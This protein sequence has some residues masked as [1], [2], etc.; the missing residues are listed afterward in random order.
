MPFT[1][2]GKHYSV[3][4]RRWCKFCTDHTEQDMVS[5]RILGN[6]KPTV[7]L[8]YTREKEWYCTQCDNID[9]ESKQVTEPTDKERI[10]NRLLRLS[11]DYDVQTVNIESRSNE[12]VLRVRLPDFDMSE[13]RAV[14]YKQ[15]ETGFITADELMKL[16]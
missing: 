15:Q 2:N 14:Q 10:F 11:Q 3:R 5:N 8:T 12:I 7:P 16:Q 13:L 1:A 4:V 9:K 6:P